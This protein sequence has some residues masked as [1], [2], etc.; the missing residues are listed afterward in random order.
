MGYWRRHSGLTRSSYPDQENVSS[1]K[2]CGR[3]GSLLESCC[4]HLESWWTAAPVD[5]HWIIVTDAVVH[6]GIWQAGVTLREH[7]Y[8]HITWRKPHIT[9]IQ[10]P[11]A[12][13]VTFHTK[14]SC[15]PWH[16][17]FFAGVVRSSLPSRPWGPAQRAI[18]GS[19]YPVFTQSD[20]QRRRQSQCKGLAPIA[21][22]QKQKQKKNLVAA[23][24]PHNHQQMSLQPHGK[25]LFSNLPFCLENKKILRFLHKKKKR[26]Q[27]I[28]QCNVT[29]CSASS[30][31][32][33]KQRCE[34]KALLAESA[35]VAV[36]QWHS[37][38]LL[39][40]QTLLNR[41]CSITTKHRLIFQAG[42]IADT[43]HLLTWKPLDCD[44]WSMPAP[45]SIL[46]PRFHAALTPALPLQ[47]VFVWGFLSCFLPQQ[48]CHW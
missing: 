44:C 38:L 10:I 37:V 3:N 42:P 9:L 2:D 27:H 28:S 32:N 41:C 25:Q 36:N 35:M 39:Y 47:N 30:L 46:P 20:S 45:P 40:A 12:D 4:S 22:L 7:R 31:P 33:Y 23:V 11:A 26:K 15:S 43:W 29:V 19:L 8:V 17:N 24:T 34:Q 13:L 5:L 14:D 16:S 6:A 21:L 48:L 1:A 18:P